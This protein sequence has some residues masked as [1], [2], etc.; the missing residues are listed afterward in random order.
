MKLS[1]AFRI[2]HSSICSMRTLILLSCYCTTGMA[3]TVSKDSSSEGIN[4]VTFLEGKPQQHDA[5][6]TGAIQ[7]LESMKTSPSCNRMAASKLVM[8]CQS[9][10]DKSGDTPDS[11]TYVTLER[12]RSLYAARLAICEL[13]GAGA[14]V[15]RPCIPIT[16]SAPPKKRIFGIS[17]RSKPPLSPVDQ[18][19]AALL[20][21]CL[22]TLESRPQWW[23]SY[24]NNRQNAVV[25]CQ[26][27]RIEGEK[28]ELL[29]LYRSIVESSSK[30]N[31][32][33]QDALRA[34]TA[35]SS[36]YRAFM[37]TTEA[38]QV[39]LRHEMR[40]TES[41]FK[42]F[43]A[44]I[45]QGIEASTHSA[46]I[47]LTSAIENFQTGAL[48]VEKGIQNISREA[49]GLQYIIRAIHD[50][51][52]ARHE[53]MTMARRR[54]AQA[55]NDLATTIHGELETI[56]QN[57]V[58]K[59]S[60]GLGTFDASLQWLAARLENVL[61]QELSISERLRSFET[62][63]EQSRLKAED[64]QKAQ[65]RQFNTTKAQLKLQDSLHMQLQVSHALLGQTAAAA[66]NL[67][68]MIDEAA[69]QYKGFPG[70]VGLPW[71]YSTWMACGMLFIFVMMQC[72]AFTVALLALGIALFIIWKII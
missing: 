71:Q 45:F 43:L 15:P 31:D 72:P 13:D 27:A 1:S 8:S 44:S 11:E 28:E 42:S 25:I 16:V 17:A 5:I 59:I 58:V 34:A 66:A 69:A 36:Q 65:V 61:Q 3:T 39:R 67:Q 52:L 29:E 21:G 20:E 37:D 60:H 7:I 51:V 68:A 22:K 23:T 24:S 54:E 49:D 55:H 32:G 26:A 4:L 2:P 46:V 18:E 12:V 6:Y 50:E 48:T 41:H 38:M 56:L 19:S 33:L 64:L 10:G 70:L 53:E 14:S 35:Q 40:E 57:E 47:A 30:L 62:S 63:L 9:L